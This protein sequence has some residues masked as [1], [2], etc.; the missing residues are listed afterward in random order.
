M[1]QLCQRY[2]RISGDFFD[3][4]LEAQ[5]ILE[6]AAGKYYLEVGKRFQYNGIGYAV[7]GKVM[8]RI[9]GR[10]IPYLFQ[11]CLFE[12]LGARHTKISGTSGDS[13]SICLDMAKVGQLLLN[14]GTYGN[15]RF[16]SEKTFEKMLPVKLDRLVPTLDAEWGI[17][18]QGVQWSADTHGLSGRTISHGAASGAILIIEPEHE[19]VIVSCRNSRGAHRREYAQRLIEACILPFAQQKK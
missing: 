10:A 3:G 4:S 6:A 1:S 12:P 5:Q 15:Y 19:L 9:S 17:G 14:R 16:F 11:E 8:E 13:Y 2:Q 7:A 18:V